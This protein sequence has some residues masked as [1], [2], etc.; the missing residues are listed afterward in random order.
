VI[1]AAIADGKTVLFVAEKMA[2]LDVVKRR[3]DQS[4]AGDACLELHSNKANKRLLLDELRRTWELGSPRGDFADS[5]NTRL[6]DARDTLNAH[7]Q[8]MH[9]AHRPSCLT[10]YQVIGELVRLRDQGH[11][12]LTSCWTGQNAGRLTSGISAKKLLGELTERL[13]EIGCP[14]EHP[15]RGV[16]LES[17]FAD[18]GR[19]NPAP[20]RRIEIETRTDCGGTERS[21]EY[22]GDGC[23]GRPAR[24]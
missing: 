11:R 20:H 10:P 12:P 14:A 18:A 7:A 15:W 1:A 16:G 13:H 3:L 24:L 8:R 19:A 5:L 4:G 23:A 9:K 17:I 6:Q 2:A 21:D 22:V